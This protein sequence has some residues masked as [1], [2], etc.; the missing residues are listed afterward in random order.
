MRAGALAGAVYA[1]SIG[2]G[3]DAPPLCS[4][5]QVTAAFKRA[6]LMFHPD[7]APKGD[8]PDA[9]A[10]QALAE[11]KFKQLAPLK[12]AHDNSRGQR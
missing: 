7:R 6:A 2:A 5:A 3:A 8:A 10:A 1:T 12:K 4:L 11:E 9:L